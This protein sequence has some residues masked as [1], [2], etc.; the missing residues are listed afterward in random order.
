LAGSGDALSRKTA[1]PRRTLEEYLTGVSEP[2][3]S[4]LLAIARAAEVSLEWLATGEGEPR[5]PGADAGSRLKYHSDELRREM[6]AAEPSGR[7]VYIPLYDIRAGAGRAVVVDNG[8]GV[9]DSLAFKE[10]WIRASLHVTPKDLRLVYVEGDSMEPDL[11]AGDII[12]I[13]HTDTS[14]RREGI[15]VIRMD[16]ALLV[17]Y[18]QRLPGGV[19]KVMSRNPAYQPFEVAAGSLEAQN[20]FAVV[21]RV[22][23]ACRRF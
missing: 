3:A 6:K 20:S 2:K 17:K 12:L 15:Y 21:G 4:R 14:A 11:R 8:E 18:L 22:V 16:D 1:I 7:Y 10:D 13:D 23:W 5:G 9:V 19:I